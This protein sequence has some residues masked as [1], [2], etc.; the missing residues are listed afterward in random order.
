MQGVARVA[1]VEHVRVGEMAIILDLVAVVRGA[2]FFTLDKVKTLQRTEQEAG[3]VI[4]IKKNFFFPVD[5]CPPKSTPW[6]AG[7]DFCL[8]MT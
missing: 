2:R 8:I 6:Q 3:E 4:R 5:I 7:A 1:A